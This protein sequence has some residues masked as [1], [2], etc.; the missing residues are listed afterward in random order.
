MIIIFKLSPKQCHDSD[1][2]ERDG[3]QDDANCR[4]H[5]AADVLLVRIE[6]KIQSGDSRSLLSH[7]L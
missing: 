3:K 5:G 2:T 1:A 6:I 4:A 7:F